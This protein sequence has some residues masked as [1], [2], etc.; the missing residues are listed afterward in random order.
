MKNSTLRL[1]Y[2]VIGII[3]LLAIA[4]GSDLLI[5]ITKPLLMISIMI[6]FII[7]T[8]SIKHNL[9][10]KIILAII[11][12]WFG[13]M[14][15][16]LDLNANFFILGLGSFLAA[17]IAYISVNVTPGGIDSNKSGGIKLLV[18]IIA[19]AYGMGMIWILWPGLEDLK[20]PVILY[21]AVIMAMTLTAFH[22]KV[23]Y[24]SWVYVLI[25]AVLFVASDSMLAYDKFVAELPVGRV[26]VMSSYILAQ[27]FLIKGYISQ[28]KETLISE[29]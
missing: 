22:R 14:F 10:T 27:Y 8:G 18:W 13:D 1:A 15:L 20:L 2:P 19:L 25:G 23:Y 7:E 16:M 6:W 28:L 4:T 29:N 5:K 24:T 26:L 3:H 17:H 11:F 12:S 21:T 9:K